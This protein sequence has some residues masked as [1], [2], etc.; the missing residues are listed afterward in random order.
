[1][2]NP[3]MSYTSAFPLKVITAF[4]TALQASLA[5]FQSPIEGKKGDKY[6]ITERKEKRRQRREKERE[7]RKKE[8]KKREK[9]KR[10]VSASLYSDNKRRIV[11]SF[12]YC[13]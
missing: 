5:L 8:K 7:E 4:S 6:Y 2:P 9:K 3:L 11:K 13:F 10:T 12:I 1:M